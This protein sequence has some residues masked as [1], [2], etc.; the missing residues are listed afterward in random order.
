M[1]PPRYLQTVGQQLSGRAAQ[2][3]PPAARPP[4]AVRP[5]LGRSFE[6]CLDLTHALGPDFPSF[7]D[8][9][10]ALERIASLEVD[11][12]NMGRWHLIEHSGTHID[13]PL[14]F[15]N[16]GL[17]V[18]QIPLEQLVLPLCVVDIRA[19]ADLDADTE[20]TPDDLLAFEAEHGPIPESACVAMLS[21]WDR[22]VASAKFRNDDEHGIMHFPGFHAEAAALLI[23]RNAAGIA[24]DTLSLDRGCCT[25]FAT[26]ALWLPS[27]RWG[28]EALANLALLPPTG[29]TLVVGCPRIKGAT[30]APCRVL[31]LL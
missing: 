3:R 11:G 26:H 21:G 13:A 19:R 1:C 24:V 25:D 5:A 2:T 28:L 12:Y 16:G 8:D 30:G 14:H 29:A 4:A 10:F 20:L 7:D 6:R 31:A 9:A 22:H 18:D 15:A 17:A 23:A 27:G